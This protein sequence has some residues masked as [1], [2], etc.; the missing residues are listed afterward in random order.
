[1][2]VAALWP[3]LPLLIP[4]TIAHLTPLQ[5]LAVPVGIGWGAL[6]GGQA[7]RAA[8]GRLERREPEIFARVR[9][10]VAA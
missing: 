4:G 6:L 2:P 5:W 8:L 7:G 10:P 3:A 9:A 1:M